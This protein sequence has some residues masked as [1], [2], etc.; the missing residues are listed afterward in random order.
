MVCSAIKLSSKS[1]DEVEAGGGLP[2]G[3]D[4]RSWAVD[5]T[6]RLF[7]AATTLQGHQDPT[8]V[9]TDDPYAAPRLYILTIAL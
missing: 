3:I 5:L 1:P 8:A 7:D 9:T 6:E 2:V 4:L